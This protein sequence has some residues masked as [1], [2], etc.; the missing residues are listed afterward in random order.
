MHVVI[1]I[2]RLFND[3]VSNSYYV[4]S[5]VMMTA[6][7]GDR[8]E[9]PGQKSR[10]SSLDSNWASPNTVQESSCLSQHARLHGVVSF[11]EP[12]ADLCGQL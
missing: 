10:C 1:F 5:I 6:K 4:A 9:T 8:R 12:I 7:N 3:A 11:H 2:G